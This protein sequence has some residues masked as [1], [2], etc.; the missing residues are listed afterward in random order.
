MSG[1]GGGGNRR[2][3]GMSW[4]CGMDAGRGARG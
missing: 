4:N 1:G 2:D 3:A